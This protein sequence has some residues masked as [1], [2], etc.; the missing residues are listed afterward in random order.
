LSKARVLAERGDEDE[1][2]YARIKGGVDSVAK[3]S[4]QWRAAV[5]AP[6]G[7]PL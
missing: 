2:T 3:H 1:L 4:K 5:P 7:K 6:D